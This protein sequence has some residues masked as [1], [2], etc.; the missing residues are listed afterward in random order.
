MQRDNRRRWRER[1]GT[2]G[3]LHRAKIPFAISS[4]G[5]KHHGELLTNLR[6]A[7]D[8]GLTRN[9]ALAALTIDAARLLGMERRLGS[10]ETGKLAHIVVMTGEFDDPRS[11]VR[12]VLIEGQ[13]FEYN[14][15]AKPAQRTHEETRRR[16]EAGC[17]PAVGGG[18]ADGDQIGSFVATI[19]DWRRRSDPECHRS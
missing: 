16:C 18:S 5:L 13:K 7:I 14:A 10:L 17:R 9:G 12:Y 8:Q 4:E 3:A 19:P 15:K 1:V 11:Q 2:L 6:Y